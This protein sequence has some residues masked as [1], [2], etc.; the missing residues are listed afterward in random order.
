MRRLNALMEQIRSDPTLDEFDLEDRET[1]LEALRTAYELPDQQPNRG[2]PGYESWCGKVSR[3][4]QPSG[5]SSIFANYTLLGIRVIL[6]MDEFDRAAKSYPQG[7]IFQWL[8]S[9]SNKSSAGS[10]LNLS[11]VLLSRRRVGKIAHHMEE[12]SSFESAYPPHPLRGFSNKDLEQYFSSYEE[13][14]CGLPNESQRRRILYRCGRHPALLMSMRKEAA[15]LDTPDWSVDQVWRAN[16]GRFQSVYEKM[17]T[18]LQ[19]EKTSRMA[20]TTMMDAMI[21]QFE[22]FTVDNESYHERLID[23]GFA[24]SVLD[25]DAV[26][27][28]A[29]GTLC[30]PDIFVLAGSKEIADSTQPILCEP[31]SP[32]FLDYI[33]LIWKPDRQNSVADYLELTE[34]ALRVFLADGLKKRYGDKWKTAVETALP[35]TNKQSYLDRLQDV[36]ALNGYTGDL[37]MLDVLSFTDYMN[38][39]RANW[40]GLFERCFTS[41]NTAATR[42]IT[43]LGQAMNY[44]RDCRN[45]SAHGSIKVLN[46]QQ[47][48][49]LQ[50][51]CDKLNE[52]ISGNWF[53]PAPPA[54]APLEQPATPAQPTQA[55]Q[56]APAPVITTNPAELEFLKRI[57]ILW[58]SSLEG[59]RYQ[60]DLS[61]DGAIFTGITIKMNGN[62]YDAYAPQG[63]WPYKEKIVWRTVRK[64][65]L[66]EFH[67][68][69]K[70]KL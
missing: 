38:I 50:E 68:V 28:P 59:G 61:V 17:C 42:S 11:I 7:D 63:R 2:A 22:F 1:A 23:A 25:K 45:T 27:N 29:N 65:V 67:Q 12:G 52:V 56:P 15:K 35:L 3:C 55:P 24:T 51:T 62:V 41:Y 19:S 30:Y 36:A 46:S 49:K 69:D 16:P 8:F 40:T 10:H 9:L 70:S 20:N 64:Y 14:P 66:A 43:A 39:I 54:P 60:V 53:Q 21:Y 47:L 31:L 6:V 44:L 18:Q 5:M 58:F 4:M 32:Y 34:R 33:R 26:R 13:L 37:S 57:S 48:S